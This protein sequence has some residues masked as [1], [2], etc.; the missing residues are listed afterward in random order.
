MRQARIDVYA[1]V[2]R[3]R[4]LVSL[5]TCGEVAAN[6]VCAKLRK[7]TRATTQIYDAILRPS[8][9]R[10][11]Q[12]TLLVA[13]RLIRTAPVTRL[14]KE[15]GIERT[16][17]TRN[18]RLLERQGLIR[19]R[20][21]RDRRVREVVLTGRGLEALA[22]AVPLWR[23]A[24][25]RVAR[26]LGGARLRRLQSDLTTTGALAWRGRTFRKSRRAFRRPA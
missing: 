8:G 6:C 1:P 18:L 2:V 9:L 21:G 12:F 22:R 15:L 11:T 14:A 13:T 24:Q 16:T 17:L 25:A 3:K 26:A 5:T 20:P 7:A 10:V 19:V 4:T 23:R